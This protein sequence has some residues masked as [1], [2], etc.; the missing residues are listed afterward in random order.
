ME[1]CES[2]IPA[3]ELEKHLR[4]QCEKFPGICYGCKEQHHMPNFRLLSHIEEHKTD[5]EWFG[6]WIDEINRPAKIGDLRYLGFESVTYDFTNQRMVSLICKIIDITK[7]ADKENSGFVTECIPGNIHMSNNDIYTGRPP[8]TF[9]RTFYKEISDIAMDC[10]THHEC[11]YGVMKTNYLF[12]PFYK[13][14]TC[15]GQSNVGVCAVCA[16]DCHF[17][18]ELELSLESDKNFCDCATDSIKLVGIKHCQAASAVQVPSL[19]NSEIKDN[20]EVNVS[21]QIRGDLTIGT[22]IQ[23]GNKPSRKRKLKTRIFRTD[24]Q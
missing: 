13:C 7:L 9:R 4:F 3:K 15:P 23:V 19:P 8:S 17:G 18:H 21:M 10:L 20:F 5:A 6:H 1:G 11:S 2:I 22:K 16:M 24:T 12:Q 14:K